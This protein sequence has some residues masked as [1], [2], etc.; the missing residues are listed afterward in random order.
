MIFTLRGK[1]NT[2]LLPGRVK[3]NREMM[4]SQKVA[5][6]A[7]GVTVQT[8]RRYEGTL[9]PMG[10]RDGNQVVYSV[11]D[12]K[13]VDLVALGHIQARGRVARERKRAGD[14]G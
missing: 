4:V 10:K 13:A 8:F 3:R 7:M 6:E 2:K 9:F 12:L 11:T 14:E 5:A 1:I